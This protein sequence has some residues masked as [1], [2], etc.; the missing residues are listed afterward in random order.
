[1]RYSWG[2]DI[3]HFMNI[4]SIPPPRDAT[5]K[6]CM[7]V[8]YIGK[9]DGSGQWKCATDTAS[10]CPHITVAHQSLQQHVQRD[11]G[12]KDS[13]NDLPHVEGWHFSFHKLF[14]QYADVI[15]GLFQHDEY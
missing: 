13:N 2:D 14:S 10:H 5:I 12:A 6:N 9:D 4:M 15:C 3:G 1:M 11:M 7:V 8:E